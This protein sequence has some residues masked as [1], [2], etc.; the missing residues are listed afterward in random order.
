MAESF[1]TVDA[2]I[3]SFPD[4]VRQS[5]EAVRQTLHA[6]VPGAGERISYQIPTLTLDDRSLVHFAGW[7]RHLS[8]YPGPDGDADLERE[9]APYRSGR[10]TLRF[11]LNEPMPLDV[12]ARVARCLVDQRPTAG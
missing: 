12:I 2:Y 3:A 4:D 8:L 5:L 11:P 9:L 7:K 6:A 10:G 1:E